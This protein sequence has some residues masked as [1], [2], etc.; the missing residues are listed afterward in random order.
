MPLAY[1]HLSVGVTADMPIRL[2]TWTDDDG[3]GGR[4]DFGGGVSL[5]GSLADLSTFI[6]RAA[7]ALM[8]CPDPIPAVPTSHEVPV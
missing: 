4:L 3:D 2:T 7:D 8:T 5:G 6:Y 1:T